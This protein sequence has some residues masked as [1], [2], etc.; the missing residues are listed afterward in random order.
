MADSLLARADQSADSAQQFT[1]AGYLTPDEFDAAV[2]ELAKSP[3]VKVTSLA[4]TATGRDVW[5]FTLGEEDPAHKPAILIVGSAEPAD[6]AGGELALRMVRGWAAGLPQATDAATASPAL[7]EPKKEPAQKTH[8]AKQLDPAQK[9][10]PANDLLQRVTIYCIPRPSPDATAKFWNQPLQPPQGNSRVTDDDRDGQTGEDPAN[11]LNGDGLITQMRVSD[12]AGK[13][14]VH[15]DDPRVLI[16]IKPQDNERG[17]YTL[18]TEGRD[19]DQDESF[20]E[21]G[22][23]GVAFSRNFTHKYPFFQIAAGPHQVSEPETRAIADFCFDHQNITAIYSFSSQENL[24]H[25]WKPGDDPGKIKTRIAAADAPLVEHL[26][27]KYRQLH[28]GKNPPPAANGAGSFADWAYF[29]YGRWSFAPRAWWIPP[30]EKPTA[31]PAEKAAAPEAKAA[32]Q[33]SPQ[34]S[35]TEKP[36]TEQPPAESTA[37]P[38]ETPPAQ[39]TTDP[40]Q[41]SVKSDKAAATAS[42]PTN[43]NKTPLQ[44]G[45]RGADQLNALRWLE[46]HQRV[47]FVPWTKIDHPDFPGQTVEIGGFHPLVMTTPP[48]AELDALAAQHRQFIEELAQALP[49]LRIDSAVAEP[50]GGGIF[51]IQVKLLNT[52]YLPTMSAM[53]ETTDQVPPLTFAWQD[54]PAETL[55]L[56]G[57]GRGFVER[58]T[59][60]NGQTKLEWLIRVPKL[61][62]SPRLRIGSPATGW[63][64]QSLDLK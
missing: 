9:A 8:D 52:G 56:Q 15:P 63:V 47:G 44:P 48:S 49:R 42:T 34:Q 38:P 60:T 16:E 54:V 21:D 62:A 24:F 3:G 57:T 51:R 40:E 1:L 5:L 32:E 28:G 22:S 43:P 20:N 29:H 64:E 17:A 33:P 18:Y 53:G 4:K 58:L 2:A 55:W 36:P 13:Y 25:P 14:A 6:L 61:P 50:L 12:P 31:K 10:T 59:G 11:D 41:P 30:Q 26:A 7:D 37:S 27:E 23:A 45:D 39:Q 19:D 46:H 35:G